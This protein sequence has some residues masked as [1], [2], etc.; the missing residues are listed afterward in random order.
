M[1]VG[2]VQYLVVGLRGEQQQGEVMKTL[3]TASDRGTIRVIDVAYLT[4][5][6]DGTLKYGQVSGLTDDEKKRF[7][8]VTGALIGYGANGAD[9]AK[10]GAKTGAEMG[11]TLFTGQNVGLS[12]QEIHD[13]IN[14]IGQDVPPGGAVF[15]ALIEHR[16]VLAARDELQKSGIAVLASG[17]VRPSSLVLL[18]NELAAAEQGVSA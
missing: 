11:S 6:T 18:G 5:G 3:R 9:G 17:F 2:P 8:A 15:V 14:D 12:A 16:W 1:T 7:G 4:K 10:A 13:T